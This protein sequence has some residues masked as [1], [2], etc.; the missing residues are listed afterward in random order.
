MVEKD[1]HA[2]AAWQRLDAAI[3]ATQRARV[4]GIGLEC[5]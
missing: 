1:Y 3:D 4:T 2:A 5:S